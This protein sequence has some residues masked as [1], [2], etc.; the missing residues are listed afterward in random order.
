MKWRHDS[1][2]CAAKISTISDITSRPE[3]KIR[4]QKC[5]STNSRGYHKHNGQARNVNKQWLRLLSPVDDIK[6]LFP[7]WILKA[8]LFQLPLDSWQLVLAK[9]LRKVNHLSI[10]RSENDN[11]ALLNCQL[12]SRNTGWHEALTSERAQNILKLMVILTSFA[13]LRSITMS[14]RTSETRWS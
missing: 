2:L 3:L 7:I 9:L 8:E 10:H 12:F 11:A 6:C 1:I 14:L 13:P 4:I 5:M